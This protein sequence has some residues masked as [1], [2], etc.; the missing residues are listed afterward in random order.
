MLFIILRYT[1]QFEIV[2][3]PVAWGAVKVR[4]DQTSGTDEPLT[5]KIFGIP[6]CR[7]ER[8]FVSDVNFPH[9]CVRR[10]NNSRLP[11]SCAVEGFEALDIKIAGEVR[12]H[13]RAPSLG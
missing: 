12:L 3:A 10:Y 13:Q 8:S 1:G 2:A 9:L 11:P 4:M 7:H 5:R 6:L